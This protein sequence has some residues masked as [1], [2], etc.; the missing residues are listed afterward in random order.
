M[1]RPG[2]AATSDVGGVTSRVTASG[3]PDRRDVLPLIPPPM[4]QQSV[5][6]QLQS[7]QRLI[8]LDVLSTGGRDVSEGLEVRVPLE[9]RLL[10]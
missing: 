5:F 6:L 1:E 9:G 7:V 10:F 8:Q 2:G 3:W 4:E